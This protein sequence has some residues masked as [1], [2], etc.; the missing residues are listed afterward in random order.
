MK[1]ILIYHLCSMCWWVQGG[2]VVPDGASLPPSQTD[3]Q[4]KKHRVGY[5][6]AV[7]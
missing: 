3:L 6:T 2:T 4:T 7:S 5:D 1:G